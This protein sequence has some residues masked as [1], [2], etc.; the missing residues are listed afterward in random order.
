M[1]E[2]I[3]HC[4]VGVS[5][6]SKRRRVRDTVAA[7][8]HRIMYDCGDMNNVDRDSCV[9]KISDWHSSSVSD[10]HIIGHDSEYGDVGRTER[11]QL[12]FQNDTDCEADNH[13][14][15]SSNTSLDNIDFCEPD[16]ELDSVDSAISDDV[17]LQ[18]KLAVWAV[19]NNI[20]RKSV[21]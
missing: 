8:M 1:D 12:G 18:T 2:N 20:D 19:N 15:Y 5:Y 16:S 17:S 11:P 7:C 14:I 10:R 13:R 9:S 21:V 4:D 6:S 3:F